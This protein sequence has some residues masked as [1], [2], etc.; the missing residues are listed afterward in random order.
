[1]KLISIT[2]AFL[3]LSVTTAFAHEGEESVTVV[4]EADWAGPTAAVVVIAVAIIV[5]KIVRDNRRN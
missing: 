5:A 2:I 3:L 1:M 4:S